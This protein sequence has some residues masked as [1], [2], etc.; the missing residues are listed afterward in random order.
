MKALILAIALLLPLAARAHIGSPNVFFE[1]NAGAYPVRVVIRPPATLP[2]IAQIDVRVGADGVTDVLLQA[3]LAEAGREAAPP[4]LRAVSV[5]GGDRLFN[6]ALWLFREGSYSVRVTVEG[7]RGHGAVVVPLNSAATQRPA[8]PPALGAALAGL[9]AMLLIGAALIVGAAAR[10]STLAPGAAPGLREHRRARIAVVATALLLAAA[11]S[12]GTA[13]WRS[14]DREFRNNALYRPLPVVPNIFTDGPVRRLHL[15]PP[16]DVP[17]WDTL[18]ADHGK[19]MHL[20]MIRE[21]DFHAFA[22]LHPVRRDARTFENILPALPAGTYRLYG[23]ITHENG[24][25][26]TLTAE[27]AIPAPIGEAAQAA[28]DPKMLNEIICQ[29]PPASVV[30]GAQP[31]LLDADDSWHISPPP[32]PATVARTQVSR[33]MGGASMVFENAGDLAENREAS[34]RFSVFT[35]AGERAAIQAYMGMRGHA[36]V[37]RDDGEVFTHLHPVGTISMAAQEIFTARERSGDPPA[38][39]TDPTAAITFPYAFPRSGAYRLWVQV[40]IE[41]RVLTGVFDVNVRGEKSL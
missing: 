14:M 9:G 3:A 6:A 8:M 16:P 10:D 27:V 12:A 18:V 5:A 35:R 21:P 19:L 26:Q 2:G 1:G 22:H 33:L 20:F 24:S 34:L 41:G 28:V 13:R 31:F 7:S 29:S 17:G 40:R 15:T 39:P 30:N 38:A 37:R 11:V 4:P 32:K 23:E 25:S 36:V